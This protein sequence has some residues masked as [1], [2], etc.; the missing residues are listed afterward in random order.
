MNHRFVFLFIRYTV[1]STNKMCVHVLLHKFMDSH[2][3]SIV[4]IFF[5]KK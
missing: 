5:E 4:Q 1:Q 2:A 3:N